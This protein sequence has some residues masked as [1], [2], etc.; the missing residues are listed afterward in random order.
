MRS[1]FLLSLRI[2]G[3]CR[4]SRRQQ[5]HGSSRGASAERS[6]LLTLLRR[7]TASEHEVTFYI[8]AES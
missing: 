6:R 4:R 8:T 7:H 2:V 5:T 1:Q 3:G